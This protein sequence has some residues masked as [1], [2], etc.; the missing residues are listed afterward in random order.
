MSDG[1]RLRESW[2]DAFTEAEAHFRKLLSANDWKRV[3]SPSDS[4]ST[5]KGKARTY[6]VPELADVALYRKA[7]KSGQ[8]VY[9]VVLDIP[10]PAGEVP[11]LEPWKALLTTPELRQEWDPSVEEAHLV[12]LLDQN[13]RI[14]KTNFTLGWPANP[15][16][17]VTI[18]RSFH[19]ASTFIDIS[20]SLPRSPDEP[21][22]LRPSPPYV[23]SHVSLFAWCIQHITPQ[24]PSAEAS[25]SSS[26]R[27]DSSG[28]R[29][30]ATCFWQH[31]LRAMW[32]FGAPSSLP[33]QLCTMMLGLLKS[34]KKRGARIAKLSAFGNGVSIERMRFQ[35]DREAL[36]IEYAI[37]PEDEQSA[38]PQGLDELHAAREQRRLTRS[39]ECILP[40]S[41]GWDVQLTTK[42][43]SEDVERLPWSVH[44]SK[45][46][47]NTDPALRDQIRLRFS[48]APLIDDHSVLKVKIV[49]EV[50]G[51]SSGLRLNGLP[52]PIEEI[53]ERDPSSYITPQPIL[54]DVSS[55]TDLSMNVTASST[56]TSQSSI[57]ATVSPRAS[58][59]RPAAAEKSILSR[60]K[61]NY[62]YFSSLLQEP[63]AKWRRTTE[64]RGVSITQLDSIDPT[65][66]VYRAEATFVG[67]GIW[68]LYGALVSPGA[69]SYWDKQ[70]ED[71]ALL[72][73]VN[74]LTE[75]WHFKSKPA[76]PAN[77]RDCVVL[78]TVYKS[79]TA[80]H[81]FAFSADEPHLFPNI[82][83]VDANIIR[84]QVD[85][86]GWAIEA[87]SPSTTLLTLLEQS[88]PKGWTNKTS[89]P[90]QMINALAGIGEFAIKCGGPPVLTRLS[91]AKSIDSRYD[92]E[93]LSF[94]LQ[95]EPSRKR[96]GAE[97]GDDVVNSASPECEIRCDVD[98]WASSLD[99]VVDPPPHSISC[100]RRHRL[101]MEGGGLWLTLS[102]D[103]MPVDDERLLV[104]V[105]KGPG[106]EKG[107]VMVNGAKIN[108]DVDELTEDEIKALG[109][110]KRVKPTRVPLDQPPVMGVIRNRRAE[111]DA[112]S[113][114][115]PPE[116]SSPTSSDWASAPKISSPL[117]RFLSY[118]V[119]QATATT[120]Q[121][122]SAIAPTS[123]YADNAVPSSSKMPMQYALDALAWIQDSHSR[124]NDDWTL[125]SDKGITIRKRMA[126]EISPTIP[127]HKGEKVI[128][129]VCAEELYPII[130]SSD[131][132]KKWDDRF[133][134]VH[135]LESFGAQANTAF[136]TY[137]AGFPFR[138]RGFYLASV[139]SRS[140][141]PSLSRRSTT[142]VNEASNGT[143][144]AIFCVSASFSPQSVAGF[145]AAKFNS[146]T[147]PI[148]R[149]FIDAWVLETLDPY[150][151]E[152]YA[153]PST[154]CTRIT[155][156]DFAGAIPVA[157]NSMVNAMLPRNILSLEAYV[158]ASTVWPIT[159]LPSPGFVV[160]DRKPDDLIAG[161]SVSSSSWRLRKR[162]EIRTLLDTSYTAASREYK[163]LITINL[164]QHHSPRSPT[165]KPDSSHLRSPPSMAL[166]ASDPTTYQKLFPEDEVHEPETISRGNG[167]PDSGSRTGSV[168]TKTPPE[169]TTPS[170][171]RHAKTFSVSTHPSTSTS[172][173]PSKSPSPKPLSPPPS[174][175]S[176]RLT[177]RGRTSTS[178]F[179]VKGEVRPP[180]DILAGE[181]IVDSKLYPEGYSVNFQSRIHAKGEV[182]SLDDFYTTSSPSPSPSSPSPSPASSPPPP[183]S[184]LPL[185]VSIYTLPPSPLHPST[186]TD[187]PS[188]SQP[189]HLVRFT[190]P[191]AK[192]EMQV[193]TVIDP[194]TGEV[195]EAKEVPEWL[196]RLRQGDIAAVSFG[197]KPLPLKDSVP[198]NST[199]AQKTPSVSLEKNKIEVDGVGVPVLD[200]MASLRGVGRDDLLDDRTGKTC[201]LV[202][203][204]A[205]AESLTLPPEFQSP[206]AVASRFLDDVVSNTTSPMSADGS[207]PLTPSTEDTSKLEGDGSGNVT[208]KE[209]DEPQ[210][211]QS[212]AKP[213]G[214][215][216]S[217]LMG[218]LNSYQNPWSRF[219]YSKTTPTSS[220][221]PT[222][223]S[224]DAPSDEHRI[225]GSLPLATTTARSIRAQR[226]YPLSTV[227]IVALIAF[228]IG[229]LLRSLLS[230]A[231]FVLVPDTSSDFSAVPVV[232][233]EIGHGA[234]P[235]EAWRELRRLFELKYIFGGWDFQ[236]AMVRRH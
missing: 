194:L 4:A 178:A 2:N 26:K 136:A 160:T 152:N 38:P 32:N 156:V 140:T 37:V 139:M 157:V 210:Q 206:I 106:K 168:R 42:A 6:A 218:F 39:L 76:W 10:V 173:L 158:K 120:H 97:K 14:S 75:L 13:T 166:E 195:R 33:Q 171:I 135:T 147:L 138:D 167:S 201:L 96:I 105:R 117:A 233:P 113:E 48:H 162:D 177:V 179:T 11:S 191:T 52:Q 137:K 107:V 187:D 43:S 78:K 155:A 128:E 203:V 197:I 211:L 112:S 29:M 90:N 51:P 219:A 22:Y 46:A 104:I 141:L 101:S 93:R 199:T 125:V 228:L 122:V 181:I 134:S 99:V 65:L 69:R 12:E 123:A 188:S 232:G 30:R 81:V 204:P 159:R 60:V 146:Y 150:T 88:D 24:P 124:S 57:S 84:T 131:C 66:V 20:T 223:K 55:A 71:A 214:R 186:L 169:L 74:E 209:E 77:G 205:D 163:S 79:P 83:P 213:L 193:S 102:H 100:L 170:A 34:I 17:A 28:P 130:N 9:R 16:D 227:I 176:S 200:E 165:V 103:A 62:I 41:D 7:T 175:T 192:Y 183:P 236:I 184:D 222:P 64:G 18:S 198:A 196:A 221:Q 182:I 116:G 144:N 212:G 86:Q 5:R 89:I 94:R 59:D 98:T 87:L 8:D 154:R 21:A 149:V 72:E 80:I 229:S 235:K 142:D 63:E 224:E 119:E 109:K 143:K 92:H 31:D 185:I 189:R 44:A 15:R 27:R 164:A 216:P 180:A 145:S 91:G 110:K 133:D 53:E 208:E 207:A 61:R 68:D 148:G 56:H 82:P 115:T 231:D 126:P 230:P 36:T 23:R 234:H 47:S 129:G 40:S 25:S 215:T 161:L 153:I 19:D 114:T 174:T 54:R 35:V 217:G 1:S 3:Q 172:S 132:R 111:W 95:Y 50:S 151:K 118:A 73:D 127:V 108:V 226:T 45:T 121:Y 225:P 49:L 85:L 202:R 70:Y 67:V 220:A 190:L 58:G